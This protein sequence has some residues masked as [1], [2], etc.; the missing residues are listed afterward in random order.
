L[1]LLAG[2]ILIPAVVSR[3]HAH[4]RAGESPAAAAVGIIVLIDKRE[5]D[6]VMAR[7]KSRQRQT[8]ARKTKKTVDEAKRA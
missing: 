8:T 4:R 5:R 7:V 2:F 6:H 1:A 3:H